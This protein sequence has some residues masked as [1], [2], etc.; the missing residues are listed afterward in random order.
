MRPLIGPIGLRSE[1]ASLQTKHVPLGA[2]ELR[3]MPAIA[4]LPLYAR[5]DDIWRPEGG[6]DECGR[7]FDADELL[8]LA[9]KAVVHAQNPPDL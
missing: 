8:E 1:I 4:L 3:R 7:P 2:I 9:P 5:G 6:D